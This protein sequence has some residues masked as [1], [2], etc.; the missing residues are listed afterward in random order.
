MLFVTVGTEQYQ[1]DALMHWIELLRKYQL[2]AE[3]I[4]VQFGAT[5]YF[6]NGAK[7]FEVL[8]EHEFR[9]LVNSANL[10]IGHCGEG[11]AQILEGIDIPYVLVPRS[12]RFREHVDNHQMEM[13]DA[14]ELRGIPIARSPGDL[15]KFIKLAQILDVEVAKIEEPE[16]CQVLRERYKPQKLM[17]VCSSGGHF[18]YMQS[19]RSFWEACSDRTW[20]TFRTG[21]TV[22]ELQDSKTI[23]GYSPTNR[24]IP[25]LIRNLFL[26][27]KVV[28]EHSPDLVVSTGAGVAVPFLIAAKWICKSQVVFVELKT[29]LKDLS[30]SARILKKLG[31]LDLT[32]VR[33]QEIANLYP[34]AVYVPVGELNQIDR[35]KDFKQA[36][37]TIFDEIAFICAP[38]QFN[39]LKAREFLNDFKSLCDRESAFKKI[40]IDMSS[41]RF[42]DSSGLGALVNC[43]KQSSAN[44]SE[45][46]LWSLIEPVSNILTLTSMNK[47]FPIEPASQTF[48][49]SKYARTVHDKK[50]TPFE[51]FLYRA[52]NTVKKIPVVNLLLIPLKFLYPVIDFDP[53]IRFH[54]SVRNPIKRAIDII[55]AL[56]GLTFTAIL[57]I[58]IAIAIVCESKGGILFSQNRCG[59]ISK[60]FR[61]WKFRSMVQNAEDLK[62]TV[63]NEVDADNASQDCTNNK[64]FKNAEDPRIT[65][66]GKFLRK[67]SLDEFPQFWNVFVGDMSLVG[68]RPPTFNELNAYELEVSYQDE[69]FTEWNRLDVK[70]GM[71]GVWQV[72][73]RSSVRSFAEVMNF[74][75]E[76]RKNWSIWYDLKLIAKTVLV[77]FDRK[78]K[79]V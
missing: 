24:N 72:N 70:P 49:F 79:A 61:I 60:P 47:I 36:R 27:L 21:T 26:S 75:I 20:V 5:T 46:V 73:G 41:T 33:S 71:T 54:P 6:P 10:I 23:W 30:L 74:D 55:G 12:H 38:E 14:F 65:R 35:R 58:P 18:K 16:L 13:A 67:T 32:I 22:S 76:Y 44:G 66:I 11:T 62:Y 4:T 28:R 19:L 45:L 68:T 31:I 8:P 43:L 34:D 1:F 59:L 56:I 7:V 77:L 39:F 2:I 25:N 50:A 57:F 3:D 40:V 42:M 37:I 63:Q 51:S 15:V 53:N 9:E 69:N 29:R 52:Y 64:F 78:N 48:R 17:L